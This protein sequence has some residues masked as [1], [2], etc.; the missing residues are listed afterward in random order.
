MYHPLRIIKKQFA[1]SSFSV[2]AMLLTANL[3]ASLPQSEDPL[4]VTG[5]L[6]FGAIVVVMLIVDLLAH[7]GEGAES[8]TSAAIWTAIWIALGLAF[9]GAVWWFMDGQAAK[10]YIAVYAL[11]KSLSMDNLFVFFIIF[12]GLDIPQEHHHKILYW[13]ILGALVFRFIFIYAGV[14]A[15]EKISWIVYVFGALLL[16]AAW[17]AYREDPTEETES[18]IVNWLDGRSWLSEESHGGAFFTHENGKRVGTALFMALIAIELSDIMFAIDSVA[19]ALS[20]TT[21]EFAIYSANIFAILGLR[22][23]YLLLE[24]I[25]NEFVYLHYGLAA[26]LAFAGFKLLTK[27]FFHV[28]PLLS[29][30][31]IVVM[32]GASIWASLRSSKS[33]DGGSGEKRKRE[34]PAAGQS[35]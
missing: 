13:G 30:G 25:I 29:V 20:V 16:W 22:S 27:E 9:T 17:R 34:R 26:V 23:L 3:A 35:Y 4:G 28:P 14:A 21:K 11:E 10:E 7:R 24:D 32:I 6:V 12:H 15:I 8:R 18:A 5:W 33:A 1:L 2:F 31:I 19:A